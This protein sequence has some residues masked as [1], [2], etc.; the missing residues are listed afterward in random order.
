[1]TMVIRD[2][3]PSRLYP[4]CEVDRQGLLGGSRPLGVELCPWLSVNSPGG[5]Q[6]QR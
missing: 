4:P 3:G 6:G 1:M 5:G 2:T